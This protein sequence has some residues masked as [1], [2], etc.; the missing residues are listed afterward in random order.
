M[1]ARPVPMVS[2][3][4]APELNEPPDPEQD[5]LEEDKLRAQGVPARFR[6]DKRKRLYNIPLSRAEVSELLYYLQSQAELPNQ[7]FE[8]LR[9]A[10]LLYEVIKRR[11]M[12]EGYSA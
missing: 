11:A 6:H 5:T 10:V 9:Q 7:R 12:A 8:S 3:D 1:S 2:P 4:F